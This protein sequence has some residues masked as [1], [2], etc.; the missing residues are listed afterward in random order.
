[1]IT[2]GQFFTTLNTQ[3]TN[4]ILSVQEKPGRPCLWL[5]SAHTCKKR[6]V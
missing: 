3:L 1:M 4:N 6:S 5:R 2:I